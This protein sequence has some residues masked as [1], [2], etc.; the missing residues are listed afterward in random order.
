MQISAINNMNSKVNFSARMLQSSDVEELN[1]MSPNMYKSTSE[2]PISLLSHMEIE[3]DFRPYVLTPEQVETLSAKIGEGMDVLLTKK[4]QQEDYDLSQKM[5]RAFDKESEIFD[6]A[7]RK[8]QRQIIEE[9]GIYNWYENI[10]E[11]AKKSKLITL[12]YFTDKCQQIVKLEKQKQTKLVQK[13][14]ARI[15]DKLINF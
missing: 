5:Y 12:D 14:I 9:L 3:R 1:K 4:D 7:K 6:S 8:P 2:H 11:Q 13:R 10:I 15:M